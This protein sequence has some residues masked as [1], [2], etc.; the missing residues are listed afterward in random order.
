VRRRVEEHLRQ[1]SAQAP[2]E[3]PDAWRRARTRWEKEAQTA[4]TFG[5]VPA[6]VAV[7]EQ[8]G[9]PV[10]A[11]PALVPEAAGV[12]LRLRRSPEAAAADG[13]RGLFQLFELELRYE[14]AWL[15]RDLRAL[16]ELGVL[17]AAFVPVEQLQAQALAALRQWACGRTVEPLTAAGFTRVLDQAR[18][19]LRG[20]V[21]R[22]T[23]LLREILTRRQ[24]LLLHAQP[25]PDLAGELAALLPADFLAVTPWP[26]LAHLPRY[27]RAM[28]MRAD[29][30]RQ[31]AARDA[32]RA[33][34]IA[35][36]ARAA[37]DLRRAGATDEAA[38]HFRWLVQ[39]YRVSVFAQEL[40]TAEPVSPARLERA[41]ATVHAAAAPPPAAAR[42]APA[43]V[44]TPPKGGPLKS[45][46]A[47]DRLFPR[48]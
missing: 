16:R 24:A 37:A 33:Q 38:E 32:E 12:A 7:G 26:Q 10:Y 46:G 27:L 20:I 36:F 17:A 5:D 31:N 35:P 23:D 18:A 9:V 45:L 14:L 22:L 34:R 44:A 39:E 30:W 8:A 25:Y 13:R 19:D 3:D 2:R 21:P 28:E 43:P 11:Y 6:R 40:G 41:R 42:P 15:E 4:W 29:R 48:G 1:L 47:L